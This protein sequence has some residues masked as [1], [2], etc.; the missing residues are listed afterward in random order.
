MKDVL[1]QVKENDYKLP[2]DWDEFTAV[3]NVINVL[4][5]ID[6]ELR[7]DLAYSILS[8]WLLVE[9]FLTGEQ[10]EEILEYAVSNDMLFHKI[11]EEDTDSIF[12]RSF[13]ALLIALI[14]IRDNQDEFL[15]ESIYRRVQDKIISYCF[16]E[17]DFRSFVDKKG[18]AHAPAHISDAIDECVL[19]RFTGLNECQKLWKSLLNLI[20]SATHVF[21]AEEDERI[22]TAVTSMIKSEKVPLT[23]LLDWIE[24]GDVPEKKDL[25]S[26]YKKINMKHFIRSLFIRL[27]GKKDDQLLEIERKFNPFNT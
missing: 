10:L 22:A 25:Y 21:D 1:R 2:H 14:L 23:T 12:L 3:Q 8:H 7:D 5:S 19:N 27:N 11:G 24:Q 17:K 26:M 20:E 6:S 16:L 18:W 4:G 13:S 15:H 9:R